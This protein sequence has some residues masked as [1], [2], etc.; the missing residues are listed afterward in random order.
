LARNAARTVEL[1]GRPGRSSTA[2][3]TKVPSRNF[4]WGYKFVRYDATGWGLASCFMRSIVNEAT[5]FVSWFET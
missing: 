4:P 1:R 3:A 5:T 2:E